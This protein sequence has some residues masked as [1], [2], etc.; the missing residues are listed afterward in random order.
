MAVDTITTIRKCH[1]QQPTNNRQVYTMQSSKAPLRSAIRNKPFQ[2]HTPQAIGIK[3]FQ[4]HS[5]QII[6]NNAFYDH[7][8][9]QYHKT[10]EN[11]AFPD[12]SPQNN[13]TNTFQDHSS[14]DHSWQYNSIKNHSL[15]GPFFY[16]RHQRHFFTKTSLSPHHLIQLATCQA[17]TPFT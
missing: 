3:S 7:Q 8:S 12:Q 6:G 1:F 15:S 4:N 2:D 11:N 10:I 14:Q 9:L 17:S 13:A 5:L 16:K